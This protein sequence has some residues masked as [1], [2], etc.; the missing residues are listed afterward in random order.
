VGRAIAQRYLYLDKSLKP[1]QNVMRDDPRAVF[2]VDEMG[3]LEGIKFPQRATVGAA[4]RSALTGGM[5]GQTNATE[6]FEPL[7]PFE[8][9]PVS[10]CWAAFTRRRPTCCCPTMRFIPAPR[11]GSSGNWLSIRRR[12]RSVPVAG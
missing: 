4:M 8:V 3:T 6:E 2:I 5:L 7:R 12:R 10:S 11:S 9:V 1:P